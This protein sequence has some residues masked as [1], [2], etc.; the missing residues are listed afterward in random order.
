MTLIDVIIIGGGPAGI[1]TAATL[2]ADG[3]RSVIFEKGALADAMQ[4]CLA[5]PPDELQAMG[6]AARERVLQRHDVDTEAAKLLT[7][8]RAHQPG[9]MR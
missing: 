3:L 1:A 2:Q 6:D 7:L 8:F 5:A 4:A 9:Q